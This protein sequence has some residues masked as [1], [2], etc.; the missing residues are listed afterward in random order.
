[1]SFK[2]G[3]IVKDMYRDGSRTGKVIKVNSKKNSIKEWLHLIE[4]NDGETR[5]YHPKF[6]RKL[7]KLERALK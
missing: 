6:L 2:V 1:M 3:D 4:W 7:T 5:T